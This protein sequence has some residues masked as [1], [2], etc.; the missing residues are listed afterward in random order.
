M[1]GRTAP[2]RVGLLILAGIG[3]LLALVWFLRGGQVNNGT[4]FVTYF[5]ESVQGLEIGSK[6]EYRGVTV[7]RVTQ[8]GV[9]SAIHGTE[10]QD[11][12]D[13]LYR[14]VYVRYIVDTTR[15]GHFPDIA[16][17]VDLG[18]R[19]RLN[20]QILT[21]LSYI[22]LD[23][24]D[25]AQYPAVAVPWKPTAEFIPS[26]PSTFAQVQNAGALLLA[27]LDKVDVAQLV[28]SLTKLSDNLNQELASGDLHKTLTSATGLFGDADAA[29]KAADVPGLTA[30]LKQTSDKLAAL[31]SSPQLKA[32]L[33]NGA[34]ATGHLA[35]LTGRMT[36]LISAM[37]A[38]VR[39]VSG[40]TEQL[41][42]GL[43]PLVR[44]MQAASENLRELTSTLRQYP[45]QVLSGPPPPVKGPL[46]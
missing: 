10:Q 28:G 18:L 8:V 31:S 4:T 27:K 46:R 34:L 39:Q 43:G 20:T 6:V 38:T 37:E 1:E 21:G 24:V 41:Q 32:L 23:F 12:S 42:T 2:L 14:Q 11:V 40:T 35:E 22:E 9:V 5:K 17:A 15:I 25:P 33:A 29:V 16:K 44:N 26:V 45:A 36:G 19:A 3:L 13:P 30:N 7:G